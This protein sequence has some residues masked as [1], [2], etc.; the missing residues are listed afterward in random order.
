MIDGRTQLVARAIKPCSALDDAR[1]LE[2]LEIERRFWAE[3][4]VDWGIV[5]EHDLPPVLIA[6]LESELRQIRSIFC[7]RRGGG[8]LR[9]NKLSGLE[10]DFA[11]LALWHVKSE[12]LL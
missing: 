1:T 6:N 5:T 2:K 3:R 11:T 12:E 9:I 8:L 10:P 4:E 7:G